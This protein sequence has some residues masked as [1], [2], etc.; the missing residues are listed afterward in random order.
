MTGYPLDGGQPQ[1]TLALQLLAEQ[2]DRIAELEG[3]VRFREF[4]RDQAYR[5]L[6]AKE[7]P[8]TEGERAGGAGCFSAISAA[9][10]AADGFGTAVAGSCL[11][12]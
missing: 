4:E 8:A 1:W 12:D 7:R 11:E 6:G 2:C 10:G 5:V 3:L 9:K